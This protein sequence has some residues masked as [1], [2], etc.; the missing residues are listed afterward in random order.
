MTVRLLFTNVDPD[1]LDQML[2]KVEEEFC[3]KTE[4]EEIYRDSDE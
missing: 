4:I 3:V 2:C 1:A